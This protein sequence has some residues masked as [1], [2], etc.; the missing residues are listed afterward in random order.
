MIARLGSRGLLLQASLF[1]IGGQAVLDLLHILLDGL[2]LALVFHAE[3]GLLDLLS[4]EEGEESALLPFQDLLP[5]SQDPP[6]WRPW[7]EPPLPLEPL[8]LSALLWRS[9]SGRQSQVTL[10]SSGGRDWMKSLRPLSFLRSIETGLWGINYIW[11]SH[12]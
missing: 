2:G 4:E 6:S 10:N 5:F 9:R 3:G 11:S 1:G 8:Y 7:P 12:V